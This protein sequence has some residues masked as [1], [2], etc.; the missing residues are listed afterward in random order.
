MFSIDNVRGMLIGTAVGDALGMPVECLSANEIHERFDRVTELMPHPKDERPAGTWTDDTQLTMV[1]MTSLAASQGLDLLDMSELHIDAFVESQ[2]RGWGSSTITACNRLFNGADP[3]DSGK[4][5]GAG[6]GTAMK[7]APIGIYAY[8]DKGDEDTV[9]DISKQ[10]APMTHMDVRP[11]IGMATQALMAYWI[12]K[13][14]DKGEFPAHG[15]VMEELI[16]IALELEE[17]MGDISP[18]YERE[19]QHKENVFSHKLELVAAWLAGDEDEKALAASVGNGIYVNEAGPFALGM[20]LRYGQ[21]FEQAVVRTVNMGGDTDT[22]AAMVGALAGTWC[23]KEAIPERLRDPIESVGPL[24]DLANGF[25]HSLYE[26]D[27]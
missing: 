16:Q 15:P 1:V 26:P 6:D 5:G 23:G 24:S 14:V 11:V 10:L 13:A 18:H 3:L 20:F 7:A 21:D 9:L 19:K 12:C 25:F 4:V 8:L 22:T 2:G 27:Q 17:E